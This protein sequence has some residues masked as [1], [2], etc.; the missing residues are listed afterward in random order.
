MRRGRAGDGEVT[1]QCSAMLC[2]GHRAGHDL[3]C[4]ST[5]VRL[6]LRLAGDAV[7]DA[8]FVFAI[9]RETG[10]C[11]HDGGSEVRVGVVIPCKA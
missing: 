3:G 2:L 7:F 11:Q 9:R 6:E 4:S 10:G 8:I 1:L 5:G